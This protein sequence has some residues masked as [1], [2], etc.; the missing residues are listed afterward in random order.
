M[1]EGISKL[2]R[3]VRSIRC[4]FKYSSIKKR[5]KYQSPFVDKLKSIA[6]K[7]MFYIVLVAFYKSFSIQILQE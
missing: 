6:Q 7:S 2:G 1:F 5:K 3:N 4:K